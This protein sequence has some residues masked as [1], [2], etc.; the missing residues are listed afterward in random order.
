MFYP[1]YT[2]VSEYLPYTHRGDGLSWEDAGGQSLSSFFSWNTPRGVFYFII[3]SLFPRTFRQYSSD[4]IYLGMI[5]LFFFIVSWSVSKSKYWY[6]FIFFLTFSY[7]N[8]FSYPLYWVFYKLPI[9]KM[10]RDPGQWMFMVS[11]AASFLAGYAYDVSARLSS[12][13][14]FK[15]CEFFLKVLLG[16]IIFY[17]LII[18]QKSS[19]L[20]WQTPIMW[21]DIL[22]SL[23]LIIIF[24]LWLSFIK[25]SEYKVGTVEKYTLLII[26]GTFISLVWF[27]MLKP[28]QT[29][30]IG[31]V[32]KRPWVDEQIEKYKNVEPFRVYP[33]MAG[34]SQWHFFVKPFNPPM[35]EL[36]EFQREMALSQQFP[37]LH[38]LESVGG[39]DNLI[40]RRY[41][42]V[43]KLVRLVESKEGII[44]FSGNHFLNTK[45]DLFRLLGMMNVKYVWSIFP[46]PPPSIPQPDKNIQLL[47][48]KPFLKGLSLYLYENKYVMGR[49]FVPNSIEIIKEKEGNFSQIIEQTDDYE[50]RGF[51]ECDE[52]GQGI[53]LQAASTTIRFTEKK[54]DLLKFDIHAS[55]GV[56]VLISQSY[57]PGWHALIDG[58][59]TKIYYANYIYIGVFVPAGNHSVVL[60]Y[61]HDGGWFDRA[62]EVNS[63]KEREIQNAYDTQVIFR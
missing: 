36:L 29:I 38:N 15:K 11:F 32:L 58:E 28:Y 10:F 1:H 16:F 19:D 24:F 62:P 48:A 9:F 13:G 45:S 7:L 21:A 53:F 46:P 49:V 59:D 4:G 18:Y 5:G 30:A 60:K 54:N 39:L 25:F 8:T 2:H 34:D 43:L 37:L 56:W 44:K 20:N 47:S 35:S 22:L 12:P 55:Q 41:D 50:E 42:K 63:E 51:I 23:F 26:S 17:L 61:G 31:D 33:L 3:E 6:F 40:S 14:L 52:C 57:V 27:Q